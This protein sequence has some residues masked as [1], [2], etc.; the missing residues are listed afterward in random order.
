[1]KPV[2]Q[3]R[4]NIEEPLQGPPGDCYAACLASIFEVDLADFPDEAETWKPGMGHRESWRL[5]L[6]RVHEWLRERGWVLIELESS[7]LFYG[8][9]KFDPYCIYSG[10]SPRKPDIN[11]AVVGRGYREII[12]DPHP[13]RDGLLTIEGKS[14]WCEFLVPIDPVRNGKLVRV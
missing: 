12:H 3:T 11:H 5:Y 8:G 6:P 1:M 4:F 7:H 2:D 10:P 14:W 9:G 13:S